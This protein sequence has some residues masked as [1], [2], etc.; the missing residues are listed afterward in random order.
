MSPTDESIK[1]F[2]HVKTSTPHSPFSGDK[3]YSSLF[4]PNMFDVVIDRPIYDFFVNCYIDDAEL[5]H[6]FK[7]PLFLLLKTQKLDN[8]FR[9]VEN[10]LITNK[11]F[12][13]TYPVGTNYG[14]YL[15]MYVYECPQVFLKDYD[16]F[17]N[18]EYSQFS[19]E[20]KMRYPRMIPM[21]GRAIESP[22]YGVLFK[23]RYHRNKV[24]EIVG[25]KIEPAQELWATPKSEYEI[26]RFKNLK[27]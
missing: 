23:T 8:Y 2:T 4:L 1:E 9:A 22:I 25:E 19:K 17:K 14:S 12:V 3:T 11:N 20:L 26:F 5:N 27:Q 24:E 15:M 7:Y 21:Q 13:Y 10:L 16:R 18:G 6:Q